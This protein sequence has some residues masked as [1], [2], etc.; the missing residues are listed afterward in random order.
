MN[1]KIKVSSRETM[2]IS[3][4]TKTNIYMLLSFVIVGLA[5]V[6]DT[7]AEG[8]DN[9]KTY[10]FRIVQISDSQP[11][12]GNE[13]MFQR[14]S[15]SVELVNRL[16]PDIV[17]VP[18]DI[19][20]SG[21]E[22]EYKRLKA[23]LAK[24]K[25]PTH[26]VPGNHDTI[27]PTEDELEKGLVEAALHREKIKQYNTSFGPDHW[28]VEYG[29][30][31]FVGF[32]STEN[33]PDLTPQR[34]IWLRETF[35]RSEKPYKFMVTHYTFEMAR[36]TVLEDIMTSSGVIGYL[37]GHNHWVEAYQDKN[38]GV[39]AFSSGSANFV[40][41]GDRYGVMCFDVSG[42]SIVC[43]W[44]PVERT[45]KP[46]GIFNL[47]ETGSAIARRRGIVDIPPYIQQLE[48]TKVTV[49]W[50]TLE[51]SQS[52][53]V[54]RKQGDDKWTTQLLKNKS[55]LHEALIEGLEP[56]NTYEYYVH[57]NTDEFGEVKSFPLSFRTPPV[58]SDSVTFAVY[59]DS[60]TQAVEHE[61]VVLSMVEK[62]GD[63]LDLCIHTGDLVGD[64]LNEDHWGR[65]FFRPAHKLLAQVPLYPVLGNHE[66]N[67][68]YYFDY[69]DLPG[70]ERWYSS[71]RGPVHFIYLDSYS[72]LTPDSKQYK[73]LKQE[74]V[75]STSAWKVVSEHTPFFSSGGH[76]RLD[77]EG[78][79]V[80]REMVN[81]REHIMPL[82]EEYNVTM[83]FSGHDHLYERS[84]KGKINYVVTGG[85]GA[86]L[87]KTGANPTQNP[88]SS[89]LANSY[90]YCIIEADESEFS[91]NVYDIA[92]E[93]LDHL[94]LT[95]RC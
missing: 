53:V 32:D 63:K 25:A 54:F 65:E 44:I 24:I 95:N 4:N 56:G 41:K 75:G 76:A 57:V 1:A 13:E 71:K 89:K 6:A 46:M 15:R 50:K 26:M 8:R 31:Q 83:V 18:G 62:F 79:P 34:R 93:I 52:A 43:S 78:M 36:G 66:R 3:K 64:G 91:L 72:P 70:N 86:P 60:R 74:L 90:H 55:T 5:F 27:W 81:L 73:W 69:F 68:A 14:A 19:T 61:M 2:Q 92:G 20:Y 30:F 59:G 21:T 80:E 22:D 23:L 16:N 29:D 35:L 12:P 39:M 33:W 37:H 85:G 88:Y 51:P 77:A 7:F 42:D 28:S 49:K 40:G 11:V 38:T 67:S 48:Q 47:K 17:I 94:T 58:Q 10:S 87:H 84:T 82:L 45:A 9:E